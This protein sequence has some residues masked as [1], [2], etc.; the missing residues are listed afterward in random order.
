M[1][2][3]GGCGPRPMLVELS[4]PFSGLLTSAAATMDRLLGGRLV[5]P[6]RAALLVIVAPPPVVPPPLLWDPPEV[7]PPP[8]VIPLLL[9]LPVRPLLD[10]VLLLVVPVPDVEEVVVVPEDVESAPIA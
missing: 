3:A 2:V 9:P 6:G 5:M 1:A 8:V 4:T 10:V 7:V